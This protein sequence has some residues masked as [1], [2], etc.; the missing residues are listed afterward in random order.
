MYWLSEP[1]LYLGYSVLAGIAVLSLVPSSQKPKLSLPSWLGPAAAGVV[2]IGSFIPVLQIIMF[3]KD[4]IGLYASF[5]AVMFS[6][7]EGERYTWILILSLLMAVTSRRV[8]KNPQSRLRGVLLLLLLATAAAMSA[9]NHAASLMGWKG[10]AGY[11]IHFTAMAVWSGTLFIAGFYNKGREGWSSYLRWFHPLAV[12]AVLLV[13]SS[14]LFLMSAVTPQPVQSWILPYG[15][16]L[17]LKH[18]L[19][20]PVLVFGL[21]NGRW[22]RQR[23]ERSSSFA[24][25]SW[26]KAEGVLL[27][28]I[29][30]VTGFLNQQGAPHAY[31]EVLTSSFSAK[32]FLWF[33]PEFTEGPIMLEWSFTGTL[34]LLL[35]AGMLAGMLWSFIKHKKAVTA[36]LL[37]LGA[38]AA[39]Y[40][41]IM[42][43]VA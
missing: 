35:A 29:Y 4:D 10:Q 43:S 3:F 11:F 40:A 7:S 13:I 1:I 22:V 12:T 6:F 41:G 26:A 33:H 8:I 32:P 21:V 27:F 31:P 2:M 19:I 16:A 42:F 5:E 34:L 38:A 9:F 20:L 24:P 30:V 18:I 39:A 28:L 25:A 37:S 36:L 17:L 15:Q 23:L 14:G